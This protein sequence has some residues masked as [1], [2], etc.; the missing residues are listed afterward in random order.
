MDNQE[1]LQPGAEQFRPEEPSASGMDQQPVYQQPVYQQPVYQQP[2]YQYPVNSYQPYY[3]A[4]AAPQ[5]PAP[6]PEKAKK[7]GK[8]K[9]VGLAVLAAFLVIVLIAGSCYGTA[10]F[11]NRKWAE[12]FA[13]FNQ[14][15]DNKIAAIKDQIEEAKTPGESVSGTP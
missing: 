13:V 14:V 2:V 6:A 15:M 1:N 10:L 3:A 8:G 9:G 7:P 5:Q 12:D 4:P 11:M